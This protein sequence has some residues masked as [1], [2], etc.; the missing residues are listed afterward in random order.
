M[1]KEKLEYIESVVKSAKKYKNLIF[2][3]KADIRVRLE[4][5]AYRVTS[6]AIRGRELVYN[7]EEIDDFLTAMNMAL[8]P[9]NVLYDTF[10]AMSIYQLG[11]N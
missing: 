2:L 6:V 1:D 7:G 11:E 10:K 4:G 8:S 9:L 3:D 5:R